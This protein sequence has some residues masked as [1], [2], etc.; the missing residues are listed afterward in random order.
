MDTCRAFGYYV[1]NYEN[2]ELGER[3]SRAV[4][5]YLKSFVIGVDTGPVGPVDPLMSVIRCDKIEIRSR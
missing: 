3:S 2:N 4:A 5:Q 1:R